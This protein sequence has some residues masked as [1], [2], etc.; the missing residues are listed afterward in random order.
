[1][2]CKNNE[3]NDFETQV[4]SSANETATQEG[5]S[6]G[7]QK[8][9][10]KDLLKQFAA[11]GIG[12]AAGVG[13]VLLFT[14]LTAPP[15]QVPDPKPNPVPTPEPDHFD[16][17][18]VPI[19]SGVNDDMS[20]SEAFAAARKEAGPGGVF[21]WRGGV[22]GT[23]YSNEWAGLSDEYK[24]QFNNYSYDVV[25][26]DDRQD[27]VTDTGDRH[28]EINTGGRDSE[29]ETG[30]DHIA[31]IGEPEQIE[32]GGQPVTAIPVYEGSNPEPIAM[33]VDAD[34]DGVYDL[35]V[36]IDGNVTQ[37]P[38]QDEFTYEVIRTQFDGK[39]MENQWEQNN[40]NVIYDEVEAGGDGVFTGDETAEVLGV[41]YAEVNGQTV[42]VAE[43]NI[44][45]QNSLFIDMDTDGIFDAAL[46]DNG[47][48]TPDAYDIRDQNITYDDVKDY[49]KESEEQYLINNNLPDY[50]NDA[51]VDTYNA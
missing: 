11:G 36:D 40:S 51:S 7:E 19:A 46:V 15:E 24:E 37:T 5:K 38:V 29:H 9:S 2:E 8:K 33:Y 32:I 48:D 25:R 35:R 30:S 17:S 6:S 43:V 3:M 13:S 47:T 39:P 27:H 4:D 49:Q 26:H 42:A 23:Y 16:G 41:Q 44:D 10:N 34:N 18:E 21:E 50:T 22:Y 31:H 1:M 12:V 28:N 20:F 14:S 45:G